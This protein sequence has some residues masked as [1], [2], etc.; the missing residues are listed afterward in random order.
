M[1]ESPGE[2]PPMEARHKLE[3]SLEKIKLIANEFL[4]EFGESCGLRIV[5]LS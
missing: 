4:V 1:H 3:D 5:G 2:R